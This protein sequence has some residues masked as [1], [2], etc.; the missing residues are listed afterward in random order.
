MRRHLALVLGFAML[1]MVV[2][3]A[4]T[5]IVSGDRSTPLQPTTAAGNIGVSTATVRDAPEARVVR[6]L[7]DPGGVRATHSHDDV[8]FHLFVPISGPMTL[9]M[10]GA[11][12]VVVQ[13]WQ[14]YSMTR[15]TKHG[16]HN[17][18]STPAEVLEIFIK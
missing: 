13:P 9:D 6:V 15:G 11:P 3:A 2:P 4:Q 1:S 17:P 10:D 14:P 18:G 12:S 5:A 16:F 8:K 7:V